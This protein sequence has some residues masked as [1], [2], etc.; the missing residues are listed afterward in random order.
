MFILKMIKV[1]LKIEYRRPDAV[2]I[3]CYINNNTLIY[4]PSYSSV[5]QYEPKKWELYQEIIIFW[6]KPNQKNF[7]NF[8]ECC[9]FNNQNMKNI[10]IAHYI[11]EKGMGVVG[12]LI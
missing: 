7:R 8:S 2:M 3:L 12:L 5:Y 9:S 1:L 4:H 11:I 10:Y 6:S